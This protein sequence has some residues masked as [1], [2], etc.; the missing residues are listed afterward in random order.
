MISG[1]VGEN[2][3][4]R[5]VWWTDP[6]WNRAILPI[7]FLTLPVLVANVLVAL[8]PA[9]RP[10]ITSSDRFQ[11]FVGGL[12]FGVGFFALL[13]RARDYAGRG[14]WR[15]VFLGAAGTSLATLAAIAR[16]AV[17]SF[18]SGRPERAP[19][20]VED[21]SGFATWCLGSAVLAVAVDQLDRRRAAAEL[22]DRQLREARD[23]ALRARLAP[24]FIFNSLSTLQAQI[25]RDPA[26]ASATAD[27]LARLF[28]QALDAAG[29]P[30]VPLREELGFVEA[31]LGVERAR[32]GQRLRVKVDVPEELEDVEIPPLSLQALVENA[33]RHGIAPRED[34]GEI[35]VR[36]RRT[37]PGENPGIVV[38]VENP[39]AEA[40]T[41]GTGTGLEAL[42][43]RLKLP[44]DLMARREGDRFRA[45]FFWG[46]T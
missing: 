9:F 39:L 2:S 28:R 33:V 36:V 35:R 18:A 13:P 42:R 44:G 22:R 5:S 21:W 16:E 15:V 45:E 37:G 34:G 12:A 23:A 41:P 25:E 40:A 19:P 27:A 26:A 17:Q 31:Y 4:K 20:A 38:S 43:G 10:G 8:P 1:A 29:R 14:A 3:R 30:L 46:T 32:L 24:H 11:S 7:P 6:V